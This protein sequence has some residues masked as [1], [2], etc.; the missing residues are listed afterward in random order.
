MTFLLY[1]FLGRIFEYFGVPTSVRMLVK[2][3][4]DWRN[5][6]RYLKKFGFEE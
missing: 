2:T 1:Y 5:D 4:K 6:D 3:I